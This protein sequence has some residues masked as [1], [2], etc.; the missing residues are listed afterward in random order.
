MTPA[1]PHLSQVRRAVVLCILF[2]P[3]YFKLLDLPLL[4]ITHPED[5]LQAATQKRVS[6]LSIRG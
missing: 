6:L 5:L 4:P 1:S 2:L 3:L